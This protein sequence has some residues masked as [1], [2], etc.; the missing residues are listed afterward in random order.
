MSL[1]RED[2]R[3]EVEDVI[4]DIEFEKKNGT[5]IGLY[6]FVMTEILIISFFSRYYFDTWT[7][8]WI[9]FIVCIVFYHTPV[10]QT[11]FLLLLSGVWGFMTWWASSY[12]YENNSL[13]APIIV[14]VIALVV[15]L[16]AK[17]K[18]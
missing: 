6:M 11:I 10:L 18:H 13:F 17:L 8:F 7:A 2:I 16:M 3:R 5:T 12:F 9:T 15:H 4:S 1:D 14:F